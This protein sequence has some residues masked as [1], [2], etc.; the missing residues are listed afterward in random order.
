MAGLG[1]MFLGFEGGVEFSENEFSGLVDLVA[2]L[3]IAVHLLY[4]EVDVAAWK[5]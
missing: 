5:L 4:V 1:G 3:A 2:E